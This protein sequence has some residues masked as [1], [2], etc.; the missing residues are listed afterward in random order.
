LEPIWNRKR[1]SQVFEK[2]R[3]YK[4]QIKLNENESVWSEKIYLGH[5]LFKFSRH[6]S[7][8]LW[9]IQIV[10]TSYT[11]RQIKSKLYKNESVFWQNL[12]RAYSAKNVWLN[13]SFYAKTVW[14]NCQ[15]E[16]HLSHKSHLRAKVIIEKSC[17][18]RFQWK[19]SEIWFGFGPVGNTEKKIGPIL[20]LP[21]FDHLH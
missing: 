16:Y 17:G 7:K 12:F 5:I 15:R 2:E 20:I 14:Q 8:D 4:T 18:W 9:L 1:L 10:R 19:V 11:K 13:N 21:F 3:A 6:F